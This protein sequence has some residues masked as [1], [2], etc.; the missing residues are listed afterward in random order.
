MPEEQLQELQSEQLETEA[1]EEVESQSLESIESEE[2]FERPAPKKVLGYFESE[3]Q[4]EEALKAMMEENLYYRQNQRVQEALR[5][6]QQAIEA[7]KAQEQEMYSEHA[8]VHQIANSLLAEGRGPEAIKVLSDHSAKVA[9]SKV[10]RLVEERLQQVVGP[11]YEKRQYLESELGK[12]FPHLADRAVKM[13][14]SGFSRGEI[15]S[16]F[17]EA[18]SKSNVEHIQS[19]QRAKQKAIRDGYMEP[20]DGGSLQPSVTEK[21]FAKKNKEAFNEWFGV[22]PGRRK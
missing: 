18:S 7:A 16:L 6:E 12:E 19:A 2:S 10:D 3:Q 8:R 14:Q 15:A 4:A 20:P 11:A 5:A 13:L 1:Q 17:R 9:L 22:A 21:D